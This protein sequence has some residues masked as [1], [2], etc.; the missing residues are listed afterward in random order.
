MR[1]LLVLPTLD[2][3]AGVQDVLRDALKQHERFDVLVVD[4][5]SE[6]ATVAMAEAA[7]VHVV[8]Q[9]GR[10]KGAAIRTAIDIFLAGPWHA[11]AMIDA[12][13]T[14]PVEALVGMIPMLEQHDV[15]VGDR[16][17]GPLDSGSMSRLN[18]L[19]NRFLSA[20]ASAVHRTDAADV[21]SGCWVI[22]RSVVEGL[23]LNSLGFE[24]EAELF[25]SLAGMGHSPTWV[26]IPYR[27]RKGEAKL[28]SILDGV[29]ILRKLLVRRVMRA[30]KTHL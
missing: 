16:L 29:R 9:H 22:E 4:G 1:A 10:G 25:A 3:E 19:G 2:E 20:V 11:L 5:R 12:D 30:R 27:S 17:G 24:L 7:G 18:F 26:R 21:C 14:Y 28:T 15:L 6:D 23:R 13:G 8:Q